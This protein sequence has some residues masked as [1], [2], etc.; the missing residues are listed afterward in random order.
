MWRPV[1]SMLPHNKKSACIYAMQN[2]LGFV[3]T[4]IFRVDADIHTVIIRTSSPWLMRAMTGGLELYN[5][6]CHLPWLEGHQLL[7][8]QDLRRL[9]GLMQSMTDHGTNPLKFRFWCVEPEANR[10][11][12]ELA[13]RVY[14]G[15][16]STQN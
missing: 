16:R 2:T 10:E 15:S 14:N 1:R 5:Y 8:L 6:G 3:H 4:K 12:I 7:Y 9:V 11:A 13:M